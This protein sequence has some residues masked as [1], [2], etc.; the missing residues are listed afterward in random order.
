MF[1]NVNIVIYYYGL[2]FVHYAI[3][4]LSIHFLISL[5]C[6]EET[7]KGRS[8]WI[9]TQS[10]YCAHHPVWIHIV[11]CTPGETSKKPSTKPSK[12]TSCQ[13]QGLMTSW[14][15]TMEERLLQ[16]EVD[17]KVH[18]CCCFSVSCYHCRCMA[19][20]MLVLKEWEI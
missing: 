4:L 12:S 14:L 13:C 17:E 16:M 6:F 3:I 11:Q 5:L 19:C 10:R 18:V 2:I 1:C 7:V 15:T 20:A 8:S 9:G